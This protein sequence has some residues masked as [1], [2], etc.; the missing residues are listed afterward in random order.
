MNKGVHRNPSRLIDDGESAEEC[1]VRELKE[2]AGYVGKVVAG[3]RPGVSPIMFNDPGVYCCS[4]RNHQTD[5]SRLL[6]Y[7]LEC[8][9][10]VD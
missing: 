3:D 2:E 4:S 10:S 9:I 5:Y 7:Q 8:C 6:Q 1:A